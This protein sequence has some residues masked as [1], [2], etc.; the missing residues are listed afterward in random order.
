[1]VRMNGILIH[2]LDSSKSSN[3]RCDDPFTKT[4]SDR[5]SI[6]K[7]VKRDPMGKRIQH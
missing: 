4:I 1:M 7:N 6:G 5:D 3:T 2:F